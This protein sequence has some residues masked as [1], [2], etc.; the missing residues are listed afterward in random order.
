LIVSAIGVTVKEAGVEGGRSSTAG[1][2]PAWVDE[3]A[4]ESALVVATGFVGVTE[5]VESSA[6]LKNSLRIGADEVGSAE[7]EEMAPDGGN[8]SVIIATGTG[9]VRTADGP[10]LLRSCW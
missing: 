7:T 5:G 2:G 1:T 3:I 6:A 4:V 8:A 9:A 10:L